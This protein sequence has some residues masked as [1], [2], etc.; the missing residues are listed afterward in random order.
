MKNYLKVLLSI[1]AA[2]ICTVGFA[3]DQ[4]SCAKTGQELP[5]EQ[6]QGV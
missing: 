3:A 2:T 6:Q 4:P 5:H 1:L